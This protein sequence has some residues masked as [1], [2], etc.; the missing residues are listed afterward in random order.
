VF[1]LFGLANLLSF[2]HLRIVGTVGLI[3]L[4]AMDVT[5]LSN[6]ILLNFHLHSL[7]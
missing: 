7:F 3:G 5:C 4:L 2:K 1:T 6:Y